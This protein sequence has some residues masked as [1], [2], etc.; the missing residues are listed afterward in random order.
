MKKLIT[1][2]FTSL[3]RAETYFN[4]IKE[5]LNGATA[6]IKTDFLNI[7]GKEEKFYVAEIEIKDSFE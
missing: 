7:D 1:K 3:D 6:L 5:E 2:Y 4:Q